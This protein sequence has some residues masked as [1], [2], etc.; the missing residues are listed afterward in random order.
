L[1]TARAGSIGKEIRVSS[2]ERSR[3]VTTTAQRN[4]RLRELDDDTRRAWDDYAE[5]LREL[6][7]DEYELAEHDS[8]E[9]LQQELQGVE[10]R[11]ASLG[12]EPEET[13]AQAD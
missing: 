1:T 12:S 6:T 9:R 4:D 13:A 11:R 8:W 3:D 5:G 2:K 10:E 7:G